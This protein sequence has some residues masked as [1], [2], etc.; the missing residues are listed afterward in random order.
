MA[1]RREPL[2]DKA[3]YPRFNACK[4]A[5]KL[6]KVGLAK[7]SAKCFLLVFPCDPEKVGG[8][9]VP[10]TNIE[11]SVLYFIGNLIWILH[12][13][14]CRDDYLIFSCLFDISLEIFLVYR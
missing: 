13:F 7:K 6:Y 9:H 2:S 12:L 10:K 1:A 3:D 11:Q 4:F 14:I 5:G 8:I